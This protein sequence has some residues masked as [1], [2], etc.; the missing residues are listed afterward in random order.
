ME[1]ISKNISYNEATKSITAI[2]LGVDNTPN[3]EQLKNMKNVA[4]HIFQPLREWHKKPIGVAS[5]FRCPI[6]NETIGV[7]VRSQHVSGCA[8]DIDADIFDNGITNT[9]IFNYIKDNLDW[10]QLIVE[11][12]N[13]DGT[14]QWIHVSYVSPKLNRKQILMADFTTGKAVYSNYKE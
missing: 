4:K 1:N 9:D 2:R 6:V 8:I 3:K 5:F 11:G 7:S 14:P 12:L 13:K 10:D